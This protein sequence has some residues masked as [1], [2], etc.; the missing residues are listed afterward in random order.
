MDGVQDANAWNSKL[1]KA[2][3]WKRNKFDNTGLPGYSELP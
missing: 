3:S 1:D 2:A